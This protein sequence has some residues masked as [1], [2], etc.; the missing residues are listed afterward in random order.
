VAGANVRVT[1]TDPHGIP[2]EGARVAFFPGAVDQAYDFRGNRLDSYGEPIDQANTDREGAAKLASVPLGPAHLSVNKAGFVPLE[3]VSVQVE[4]GRTELGPVV[5]TPSVAIRGT[6]VGPKGDAVGNA[7]V[8]V[9]SDPQMPP[10]YARHQ[11]ATKSDERGQFMIAELEPGAELAI[12]A[13]AQGLVPADPVKLVLPVAKPLR[14]AMEPERVLEGTVED[15]DNRALGEAHVVVTTTQRANASTLSPEAYAS[16]TRRATT[17]DRGRFRVDGLRGGPHHLLV[18]K[19]GYVVHRQQLEPG[20]PEEVE[21]VTVV[22]EEAAEI[23]VQVLRSDGQPVSGV[24]VTWHGEHSSS[25][26]GVT[27]T[28]GVVVLS[29]VAE[30]PFTVRAR[31]PNGAAGTAKGEAKGFT[32]VVVRLQDPG[33]LK[34][35]VV[36]S[37]GQPVSEARLWLVGATSGAKTTTSDASGRFRYSNIEAGEAHIV[38]KADGLGEVR[39]VVQIESGETTTVRLEL[40]DAGIVTGEV[41]GLTSAELQH[42]RVRVARSI[43]EEVDHDGR[44]SLNGVPEGQ[45]IVL[46]SLQNNPN[47]TRAKSLTVTAGDTAHVILD[48]GDEHIVS[49]HLLREGAPA[50]G[51]PVRIATLDGHPVNGARSSASGRYRLTVSRTGTYRLTATNSAGRT[52]ASRV[53]DVNGPTTADLEI[54]SGTISGLVVRARTSEPV[55]EASVE[56]IGESLDLSRW[57]TT[58]MN[59]GFEITDVPDGQLLVTARSEGEMDSE[60]VTVRDGQTQHLVLQIESAPELVVHGTRASGAP[61]TRIT[62]LARAVSGGPPLVL[63]TQCEQPGTCPVTSLAEGSYLLNVESGD[64]TGTATAVVPGEIS[65]RL[66]RPGRL[67]VRAAPTTSSG[68]DVWRAR[69]LDAASGV[70]SPW[71][72]VW[73][74]ASAGGWT[75]VGETGIELFLPTGSYF[76]EARSESGR[77][78]SHT[79]DLPSEGAVTLTLGGHSTQ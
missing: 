6:T 32:S 67:L 19:D 5:L 11:V 56:V 35:Q 74:G 75:L 28:E 64:E 65:V 12:A 45:Q 48:F 40:G 41:R 68:S 29:Q 9:L 18:S 16:A 71:T 30:G 51:L 20:V 79:V 25:G 50:P 78:E 55:A 46:A 44:F 61:V 47:R 70:P 49:G 62:V 13:Q 72:G 22:L 3:L 10:E 63:N 76:V 34:G 17:D 59:G 57:V 73:I 7:E 15:V 77:A 53:V 54:S 14:V 23:E 38:A 31:A 21:P 24:E 33:A 66:S 39:K 37:D 26:R 2:I 52:V 69:V 58:D 8:I 4:A 27:D 36:R 43:P 60:S 1:V 42:C